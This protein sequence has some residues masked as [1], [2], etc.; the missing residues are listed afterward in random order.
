MGPRAK[1]V[2]PALL[3]TPLGKLI[4]AFAGQGE[5]GGWWGWFN[6][7]HGRYI[8]DIRGEFPPRHFTYIFLPVEKMF[9]YLLGIDDI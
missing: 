3:A 4:C 2:A 6:F 8:D 1:A 7:Q 5:G 9:P